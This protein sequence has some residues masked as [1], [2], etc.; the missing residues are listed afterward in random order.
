MI[1]NLPEEKNINKVFHPRKFI[2]WL[3]I[4]SS[5]MAFAGLISAFVVAKND[6]KKAYQVFDLPSIYF[7]S[8]LVVVVSSVL[9]HIAY[10]YAKNN[11]FTKSKLFVLVTF[12]TGVLFVILQVKG[13]GEL[14][15]NNVFVG[16]PTTPWNASITYVIIAFHMF[17]LFIAMI[18]L[19]ALM[20]KSFKEKVFN[21]N[22]VT[23]HN[24]VVFWHFLGILWGCLYLFLY[25]SL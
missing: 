15:D 10:N 1:A 3:L 14:V 4:I 5:S 20:I 7:I 13:F 24:C 8:T 19:I 6:S 22:I 12:I 2:I 9:L 17:H 23:F 16:G 25:L 18:V 21:N 11:Q